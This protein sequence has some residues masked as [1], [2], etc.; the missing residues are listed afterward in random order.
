MSYYKNI[1]AILTIVFLNS[2]QG[3]SS[4]QGLSSLTGA[5]KKTDEFKQVVELTPEQ[6]TLY[7]SS[8]KQILTNPQTA[9]FSNVKALKFTGE[10]G[11]HICGYVKTKT[12]IAEA[13]EQE[14]YIELRLLNEQ[15]IVQRGQVGSDPAKLAKVKF[16]C[17]HHQAG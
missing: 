17:R 8:L 9:T 15:D 6:T 2:L 13:A 16:V 14:F 12:E 3:C 10:P 11:T 1:A 7:Q 5:K 4:E